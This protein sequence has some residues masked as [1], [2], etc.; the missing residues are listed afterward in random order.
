[1]T[2]LGWYTVVKGI[3][4]MKFE[5]EWCRITVDTGPISSAKERMRRIRKPN[6]PQRDPL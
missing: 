2:Y 5:A 4:I 1:M 3:G 6:V